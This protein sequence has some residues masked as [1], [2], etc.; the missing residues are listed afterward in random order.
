MILHAKGLEVLSTRPETPERAKREL[1]L[2]NT[3]GQAL[4]AK[5]KLLT[6]ATVTFM[7]TPRCLNPCQTKPA[8]RYSTRIPITEKQ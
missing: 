3:L 4:I 7:R 2:Q 1:V 6:A 5:F 8:A